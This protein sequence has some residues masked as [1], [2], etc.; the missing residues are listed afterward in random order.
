ITSAN[1]CAVLYL[2]LFVGIEA[3][4]TKR[5]AQSLV[6][7]R[8]SEH[9]RLSDL[10]VR[11]S[12][13]ARFRAVFF[14]KVAYSRHTLFA[15]LRRHDLSPPFFRSRDSGGGGAARLVA[16]DGGAISG[17]CNQR[18]NALPDIAPLSLST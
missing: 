7:I 6:M 12:G 11:M 8:E 9:D 17:G 3:A 2:F 14:D 5:L 13:D 16:H 15:R 1:P 4:G 18:V 10:F